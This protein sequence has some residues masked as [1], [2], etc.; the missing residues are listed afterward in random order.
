MVKS[1]NKES[2]KTFFD[3][4]NAISMKRYVNDYLGIDGD[5]S[6]MLHCGLKDLKSD[7]V[8]GV[9]NDFAD[10][11]PELVY[12][13]YLLLVIDA[14]NNRGTYINPFYLREF[15]AK[16]NIEEEYKLF[17]RMSV[18]DLNKVRDYYLR[19][20]DLKDKVDANNKFY[21]LLQ[22]TNKLKIINKK[23]R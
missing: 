9:S 7:Y 5:C 13:G 20:K 2:K 19:Y 3:K 12:Q 8:I 23:R 16:E 10:K 22:D 18:N 6:K 1:V 4:S 15:L 17:L 14:H 21:K 11:N